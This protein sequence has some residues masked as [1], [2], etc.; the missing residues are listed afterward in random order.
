MR[1]SFAEGRMA[2]A[3][4][5]VSI[6]NAIS[7]YRKSLTGVVTYGHVTVPLVYTQVVHLAVYFYFAVALIG[8]QSIITKERGDTYQ[9]YTPIFLIAEFIFYFGWLNVASTLYNPFGDDDDDFELMGLVNRHIRV[10]MDIVNDDREGQVPLVEE[11]L[12]W[13]P[14]PDAPQDWK[15]TFEVRPTQPARS[16]SIKRLL[17]RVVPM[18]EETTSMQLESRDQGSV[19]RRHMRPSKRDH[20]SLAFKHSLSVKEE[21]EEE[22]GN[23]P[24]ELLQAVKVD[25]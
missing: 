7:N 21:R 19:V 22:E 11:D 1:E 2:T 14:P 10:C 13:Q 12:F 16:F 6:V 3:P 20:Q 25:L 8:R 17:S 4:S 5:Y 15:P 9:S 24:P 18:E 23:D